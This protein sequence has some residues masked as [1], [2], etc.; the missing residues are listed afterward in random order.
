MK[1]LTLFLVGLF[2]TQALG[3]ESAVEFESQGCPEDASPEMRWLVGIELGERLPPPSNEDATRV[4]VRCAEGS[5]LLRVDDPRTGRALEW[6][7][8]LHDV[9]DQ[10]Q[11]RL[12]A[13]ASAE[14]VA[15]NSFERMS[16]IQPV[17]EPTQPVVV[18]QSPKIVR[19]RQPRW[20]VDGL[21]TWRTF[22]APD[23]TLRVL[24]GALRLERDFLSWLGMSG[25]IEAS[26][27]NVTV[28][29][30]TVH[31]RLASGATTIYAR[32]RLGWLGLQ[33]GI[34]GRLGLAHLSGEPADAERAAAH[35]AVEPWGGFLANGYATIPLFSQVVATLGAEFGAVARPVGGLVSGE[36]EL[37]VDGL[38]IAAALGIGLRL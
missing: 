9:A 35:G 11:T 21:A 4:V 20:R 34:G 19:E 8:D 32:T 5:A 12:L 15:A 30:G 38:W 22:A 29:L 7:V 26:M 18:H 16:D 24:G 27:G 6:Q 37:A 2:P 23:N 17:R 36:R 3:A 25:E 28:E 33:A 1:S 31:A 13:L 10:A 14:L